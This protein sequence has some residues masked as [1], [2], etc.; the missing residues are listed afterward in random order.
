MP[1]VNSRVVAINKSFASSFLPN[2]LSSAAT[3]LVATFHSNPSCSL[4]NSLNAASSFNSDS[5]F[6][7]GGGLV[8]EGSMTERR[9]SAAEIFTGGG[10]ITE[11]R[12]S[13]I[14]VA[15][16]GRQICASR[17]S[18]WRKPFL[19]FSGDEDET[20]SKARDKR[21]SIV[22]RKRNRSSVGLCSGSAVV[23]CGE[24]KSR[25]GCFVVLGGINLSDQRRNQQE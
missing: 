18:T 25:S 2:S 6:F 12:L 11:R 10:S 13:A 9:L 22:M 24:S 20:L 1:C 15:C 7:A 23:V 16:F 14:L 8:V 4:K 17:S 21:A 19:I 5:G 3:N